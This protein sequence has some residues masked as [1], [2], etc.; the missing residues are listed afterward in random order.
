MFIE[1]TPLTSGPVQFKPMLFEGQPYFLPLKQ[2]SILFYLCSCYPNVVSSKTHSKCSINIWTKLLGRG[3]EGIREP[4]IGAEAMVCRV[5]LCHLRWLRCGDG[6]SLGLHGGRRLVL[7]AS[8]RQA[9]HSLSL[10][11]LLC[12]SSPSPWLTLIGSLQY[13]RHVTLFIWLI[14]WNHHF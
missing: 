3:R 9:G 1:K 6:I 10:L 11:S 8:H 12:P 14:T 13:T 7:V 4:F 5:E 2:R